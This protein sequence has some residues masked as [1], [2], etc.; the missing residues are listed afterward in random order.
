MPE[1]KRHDGDEDLSAPVRAFWS[2]TITFGLVS[3]PVDLYSAVRPRAKS[4]RLVDKQGHPLGREYRC[5]QDGRKLRQEE[6]IR[7]YETESGQRVV[8]TDEEFD[9]F[10]PEMSRDIE[11]RAFVPREQIPP[12]YYDR[13]YF[14]APSGRSAKA[15]TLLARTMERT[16][17]VGIG[18]FVMRGHEYLAAILSENGV[19]RAETLRHQAE[20][21]TPED[22]GLPQRRK[23]AARQV[24]RFVK[25]IEG[26]TRNALDMEE[27]EDRDA[28]AL[29]ALAQ[30]KL[31]EHQDVVEHIQRADEDAE[32]GT[33]AKVIDLMD[34]LRRNLSR[35]AQVSTPGNK[36]NGGERADLTH[37]SRSELYQMASDLDIP[38]RSKMNRKQLAAAI[39]RAS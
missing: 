18:T 34:V 14:L 10:A 12:M 4:M 19:L 37:S 26:L 1:H 9:T 30:K 21:R 35:T 15:Y 38:G 29:Q 31:E 5:S 32:A 20:I 22:V 28:H 2:G 23:P 25:E 8:I 17:R 13:P 7:G 24:A 3:I 16:G 6:L 11:L 39:R 33:S 36:A 27:F